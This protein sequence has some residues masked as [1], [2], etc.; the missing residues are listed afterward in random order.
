MVGV[1]N[2]LMTKFLLF[3]ENT[4]FKNYPGFCLHSFSISFFS[5]SSLPALFWF[6]ANFDLSVPQLLVRIASQVWT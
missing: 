5:L 6:L 4:L 2:L 3:F 1:K